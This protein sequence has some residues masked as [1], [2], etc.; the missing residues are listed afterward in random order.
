MT[1][2]RSSQPVAQLGS[3]HGYRLEGDLAFLNAEILCDEARLTG[4]EWALQLCSDKGIKFAELP[5]G[6]LNPNG[7]GCILV[8][9]STYALPPAGDGPHIVSMVLVSGFDGVLDTIEDIASYE[10]AVS[11]VQP[12]ME[13][14]ICSGFTND[15]I[16][17][18]IARIE[19]PRD[20]DNISGTLALELWALDSEYAGGDWTGVPVA[21]LVLGSLNGQTEWTDCH[22]TTHAGPLPEAGHLTLMLREWT[23][24]GY[25]TRDFRV[26][27]RP[28]TTP[29]KA[30]KAKAKTAEKKVKAPAEAKSK[31][32]EKVAPAA[33][34]PV[35]EKAKAAAPAPA[36]AVATAGVSINTASAAELGAIKGVSSALAKAIVAG[37]PYAKLDDVVSAK[38]MGEKLLK[39]IRANLKL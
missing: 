39:K 19:N 38:G 3:S 12:R 5:L 16:T 8:N 7:T 33:A 29:A 31:A 35:A 34:A 9:G 15:E 23:P 24:A 28:S 37:R 14:T 4:Q 20:A 26:L 1:L 25:V 11:F 6:L 18:D 21:S 22:L 32:A 13:G 17:F 27:A 30:E 2:T 10:Q 36:A